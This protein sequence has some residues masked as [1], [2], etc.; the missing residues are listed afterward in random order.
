MTETNDGQLGSQEI[1]ARLMDVDG[2]SRYLCLPKTTIYTWTS[3]GKIPGI[4]K[5]GRALR[6]ERKKIDEWVASSMGA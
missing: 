4:V 6:F 1:G 5:F 3:M 2:L